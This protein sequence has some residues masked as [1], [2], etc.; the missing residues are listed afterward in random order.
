MLV[1]DTRS[2]DV[3]VWMVEHKGRILEGGVELPLKPE[4]SVT[5]IANVSAVLPYLPDRDDFGDVAD[6]RVDAHAMGGEAR[7]DWRARLYIDGSDLAEGPF[8]WS[9]GSESGGERVAAIG[10]LEAALKPELAR[11][12]TAA[13]DRGEPLLIGLAAQGEEYWDFDHFLAPPRRVWQP[14]AGKGFALM[15]RAARE[16]GKASEP[17]PSQWSKPIVATCK[18]V[19]A[20]KS[21]AKP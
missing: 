4:Q 6:I 1:S 8:V 20:P 5:P 19:K 12:V 14:L 10:E 15:R 18:P 3:L 11:A 9:G 21:G 16:G 2:Q 17:A 7:P 13:L